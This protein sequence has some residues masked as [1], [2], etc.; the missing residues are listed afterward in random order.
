MYV[1]YTINHHPMT[2]EKITSNY[3]FSLR[4]LSS[5]SSTMA[6]YV[7]TSSNDLIAMSSLIVDRNL[8]KIKLKVKEL[9]CGEFVITLGHCLELEYIKEVLGAVHP[10]GQHL[11]L[12]L[13]SQLLI[14]AAVVACLLNFIINLL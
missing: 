13:L 7:R 5:T 11:N 10:G 14:L 6:F 3:G 2:L 4:M 9:T 1:K 8:S 12:V